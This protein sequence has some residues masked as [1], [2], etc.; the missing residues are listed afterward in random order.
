[1]TDHTASCQMG[2]KL[3]CTW[4]SAVVVAHPLSLRAM[5]R[6][7]DNRKSSIK[8]RVVTLLR[9]PAKIWY[10]LR[11]LEQ[12]AGCSDVAELSKRVAQIHD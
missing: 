12:S 6:M 10:G 5:L 11:V 4:L 7:S 3:G 9:I 1:M 2:P 8:T